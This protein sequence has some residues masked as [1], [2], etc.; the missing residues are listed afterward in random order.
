MKAIIE[1]YEFNNVNWQVNNAVG[2]LS[3][4][5]SE[6]IVSIIEICN[7]ATEVTIYD[8]DVFVGRWHIFNILS[9]ENKSTIDVSFQINRQNDENSSFEELEQAI[10]D[11]GQVMD[12]LNQNLIAQKSLLNTYFNQMKV[13]EN[14]INNRINNQQSM[15]SNIENIVNPLRSQSVILQ[16][17][18]NAFPKNTNSRLG[19]LETGYNKIADRVT[20]LERRI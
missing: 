17:Q 12:S 10:M 4:P 13:I 1:E 20:L 2:V 16:N 5:P 3:L 14:T 18:M 11:L 6:S 7:S 9:I 15:I 19:E 8:D